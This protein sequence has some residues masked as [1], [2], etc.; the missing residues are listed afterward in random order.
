MP[1]DMLAILC[2]RTGIDFVGLDVVEVFPAC[3]PAAQTSTFA[4]NL[5]D[6]MLSLVARRRS[7]AGDR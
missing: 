1:R 6:E 5:A 3:D 7:D 2:G 4:V